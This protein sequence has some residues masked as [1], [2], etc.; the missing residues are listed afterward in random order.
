M[1]DALIALG[2][3]NGRIEAER[4]HLHH[5][6]SRCGE[7]IWKARLLQ[8][9]ATERLIQMRWWEWVEL[10]ATADPTLDTVS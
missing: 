6:V 4:E 8:A 5:G 10:R 3:A 1:S 7:A 2:V 9:E